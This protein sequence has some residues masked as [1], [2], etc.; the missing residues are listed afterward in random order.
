M[1]QQWQGK[2]TIIVVSACM[3]ADGTPDFALNEV[4][5][6]YEEYENG[7]HYDLVEDRLKDARYEE[8]WVHYDEIE[9]PRF[10]HVAV[11]LYLGIPVVGNSIAPSYPEEP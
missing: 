10:L 9:A 4:E 6:T 2:R 5:V 1:P 3:A 11:K 7:V 8:P